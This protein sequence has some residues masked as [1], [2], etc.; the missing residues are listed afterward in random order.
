M[1]QYNMFG[2]PLMDFSGGAGQFD[3]SRARYNIRA[4]TPKEI[5]GHKVTS[6]ISTKR[7]CR[8]QGFECKYILSLDISLNV[9]GVTYKIRRLYLCYDYLYHKPYY[10][11]MQEKVIKIFVSMLD[12]SKELAQIE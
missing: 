11:A 3:F 8:A 4:L 9:H 12:Q 7:L 10:E 6:G 1:M 5:N 2:L